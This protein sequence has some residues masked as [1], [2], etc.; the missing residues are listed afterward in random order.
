[1]NKGWYK[2][3][4]YL[5]LW[6]HLLLKAN[7]KENEFM[8]NGANIKVK[9]G[10]FITGRT[11][12]ALETGINESKIERILTF[13][14]KNEQQIE[15][16]KTNTSRLITII[17]WDDYQN[18]EQQNEQRVN[19][20]RTTN[21][22]RVNTNKNDNNVKNDNKI[23]KE[24]DFIDK[25]IDVFSQKYLELRDLEYISNGKDRSAVGKLLKIYKKKES[26]S[27]ETLKDFELFFEQC[28]R[29]QDKW[30]WENMS[31][32]II[33]SKINELRNILNKGSKENARDK[34]I[35]E[36]ANRNFGE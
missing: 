27:E 26:T 23:T 30:F 9:S 7:H 5:Q 34:E 1:M 35:R 24:K 8:W 15:Q 3:S 20:E 17:C 16:Q 31:L 36:A 11:K 6:I 18:G 13:F 32:P 2:K 10:Q 21:E 33:N 28:L 22:Q 12:L 29:V 19:N 14:E 4:D 25:I